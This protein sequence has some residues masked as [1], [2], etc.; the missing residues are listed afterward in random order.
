M[1]KYLKP[2]QRII[3]KKMSQL[4]VEERNIV[5]QL[6]ISRGDMS[7]VTYVDDTGISIQINCSPN[8]S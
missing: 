4:I 2:G 5:E 1:Y 7:W 6:K 8:N 3:L